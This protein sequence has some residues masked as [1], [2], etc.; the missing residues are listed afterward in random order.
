M[1]LIKIK[2]RRKAN[3]AP[4]ASGLMQPTCV[5][6]WTFCIIEKKQNMVYKSISLL[7]ILS[8]LIFA[9]EKE[10]TINEDSDF[11]TLTEFS[12][13][14]NAVI[15]TNNEIIIGGLTKNNRGLG[16]IKLDS[17]CN[18][19]W[20]R[21]F[22]D[23]N[24]GEVK[25]T[26]KT[27]GGVVIMGKENFDTNIAGVDEDGNEEWFADISDTTLIETNKVIETSDGNFL[28]IGKESSSEVPTPSLLLIKYSILG[29]ELWRKV[30]VEEYG[31]EGYDAIEMTENRILI[32]VRKS[33]PPEHTLMFVIVNSEGEKIDEIHLENV[34]SAFSPGL[35][36]L[37]S[38][39]NEFI[40]SSNS[41]RNGDSVFGLNKIE[42]FKLNSRGDVLWSKDIDLGESSAATRIIETENK[43]IIVVGSITFENK[44]QEVFV[45]R[46]DGDG[47]E[48]WQKS[49][50][51]VNRHF[52]G[53]DIVEIDGRF[54]IVGLS[55]S[56]SETNFDFESAILII[57]GDGNP[58][59]K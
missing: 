26:Y 46:L 16:L 31:S 9:C 22:F 57:D 54:V 45:M 41:P 47:N 59:K 3:N 36:L 6:A 15:N 11:S 25:V 44:N 12:S 21:N 14:N 55:R 48:L 49:Y 18:E 24:Y 10:S 52:R 40:L 50:G 56:L 42:L 17:E 2:R 28:V 30:I 27:K 43:D 38:S 29:E 20:L 37:K 35:D 51:E 8:V 7:I 5:G 33:F 32:S 19:I 1:K 34:I 58:I 4:T 23:V 53:N 13:F 39:E